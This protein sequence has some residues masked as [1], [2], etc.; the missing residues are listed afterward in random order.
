MAK[1]INFTVEKDGR[2]SPF[3]PQDAGAQ[4]SHNAIRVRVDVTEYVKQV[5]LEDVRYRLQFIDGAGGFHSTGFLGLE[6]E[7]DFFCVYSLL[8]SEITNA[9]G[10]ASVHVVASTISYN[11]ETAIE[12]EIF[13]TE[14][15]KI[16]FSNSGVGSPSEY[17]YR[18]GMS[19]ALLNAE[20][21]AGRAESASNAAKEH[22][23]K[24]EEFKIEADNSA[25][26][27]AETKTEI[28]SLKIQT[29]SYAETALGASQAATNAKDEAIKAKD[30]VIEAKRNAEAAARVSEQSATDAAAKLEELKNTLSDYVEKIK[31]EDLVTIVN[32]ILEFLNLNTGDTYLLSSD[33]YILQDKNGLYLTVKESN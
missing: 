7:L 14:A 28:E 27:A 23:D 20:I 18:R 26:L 21:F 8:E 3:V 5:G 13:I 30:E 4:G 33:G 11:G 1:M 19:N 9:G 22:R 31:F 25:S 10:V 24:A 15:G 12:N 29:S 16:V 2:L 17:Q 6:E 32:K